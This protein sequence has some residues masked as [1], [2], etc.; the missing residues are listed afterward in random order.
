MQKL[1]SLNFSGLISIIKCCLI[2][3]IFTL[4]GIVA[5]AVV[6][7]FVDVPSNAMGY[8]NNAIKGVSIFVMV[9]FLKKGNN[10]KLLLKSAF[11]G[12]IYAALSLVIFSILNGSFVFDLTVLC[13]FAFALIVAVVASVIVNLLNRKA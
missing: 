4:A 3:I 2:G 8:I 12:L 7:K 6:L 9:L 11:G 13:D 5:F 10:E 1:K